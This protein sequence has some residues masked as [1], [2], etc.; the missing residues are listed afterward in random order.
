MQPPP[1]QNQDIGS[2]INEI[3]KRTFSSQ[4]QAELKAARVLLSEP[5][6]NILDFCCLG[7]LVRDRE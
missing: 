4:R 3:G 2:I 6:G 7:D 1:A 5:T